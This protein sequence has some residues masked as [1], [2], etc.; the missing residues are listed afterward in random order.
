[1]TPPVPSYI[2]RRSEPREPANIRA[3]VMHGKDLALWADCVIRDLSPSGAKIEL[4]HFYKLPPRF[5]L[6]RFDIGVAFEVVLSKRCCRTTPTHGRILDPAHHELTFRRGGRRVYA[7]RRAWSSLWIRSAV[8][9]GSR[10]LVS[11]SRIQS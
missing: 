11:R 9:A 8:S 5:V 3:R 4:S 7:G 6:L 10:P 1:M 2:E